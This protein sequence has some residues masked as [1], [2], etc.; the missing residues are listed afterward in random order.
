MVQKP[1]IATRYHDHHTAC[2]SAMPDHALLSVCSVTH[3]ETSLLPF[4][5]NDFT[6]ESYSDMTKFLSWQYGQQIASMKAVTLLYKPRIKPPQNTTNPHIWKLKN[7][8]QMTI[9]VEA[10]ANSL[11]QVAG[12]FARYDMQLRKDLAKFQRLDIESVTVACY[13]VPQQ[14]PT[15]LL[16]DKSKNQLTKLRATCAEVQRGIARRWPKEFEEK[17][18][19]VQW[20]KDRKKKAKRAEEKEAWDAK[21]MKAEADL[22]CSPPGA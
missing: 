19:K 20:L 12:E 11:W 2:G 16:L 4:A 10:D 21:L 3:A 6:F 1:G 17:L 13:R 5:L 18:M 15:W 14:P 7:V 8:K 9:I 22:Q